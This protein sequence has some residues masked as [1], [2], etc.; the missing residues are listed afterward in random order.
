MLGRFVAGSDSHLAPPSDIFVITDYPNH[1]RPYNFH[2]SE[3]GTE[4]AT[5][6][7]D[8]IIRGQECCSAAQFI[9]THD[10]IKAAMSATEPPMDPNSPEWYTYT[11][12]HEAGMPPWGGYASQLP[13][14]CDQSA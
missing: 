12:A 10:G 7:F 5:N 14:S 3:N 2:P 6:S 4:K 13:V 11:A 1:I 8:I 9:H